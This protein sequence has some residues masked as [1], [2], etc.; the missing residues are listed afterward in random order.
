MAQLGA[1]PVQPRCFHSAPPAVQDH[2]MFTRLALSKY[3]ISAIYMCSLNSPTVWETDKCD[4]RGRMS[5]PFSHSSSFLHSFTL[6]FCFSPYLAMLSAR[7]LSPDPIYLSSAVC[8]SVALVF[9]IFSGFIYL[10]FIYITVFD[11]ILRIVVRVI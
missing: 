11:C 7:C 2:G 3:L 5:S 8:H 1:C 6:S 4:P 10:I 9:T